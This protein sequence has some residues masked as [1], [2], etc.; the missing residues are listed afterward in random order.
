MKITKEQEMGQEMKRNHD[1]SYGLSN[2]H[3]GKKMEYINH[4]FNMDNVHRLNGMH[5]IQ[6]YTITQHCLRTAMLYAFIARKQGVEVRIEAMEFIMAHDLLETITGDLP[7]T[8]KN[9]NLFTKNA[10][11]DIETMLVNDFEEF[12][13]M[14][15]WTDDYAE[16]VMSYQELH[17]FK[18]CDM[19]ELYLFCKLEYEM[20]NTLIAPII[21]NCRI[22]LRD[23]NIPYILEDVFGKK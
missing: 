23:C 17:I 14:S 7:Y 10:W 19:Y 6:N 8:V 15:K 5:L 22:A 21:K 16:K 2:Y 4:I 3:T 18:A 11:K 9:Y 1:T 12:N 13:Y 20:G